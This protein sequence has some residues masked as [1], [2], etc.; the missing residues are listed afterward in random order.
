MQN[1]VFYSN[2]PTVYIGLDVHLHQWNVCI[3]YDGRRCKPFQ[4]PPSAEALAAY[5]HR[6]YPGHEYR[7]A[8][9]AGFCGFGPHYSLLEMGIYNIVFNAADIASTDKEKK[10]KTDAV[11][12]SKIARELAVGGLTPIYTPS[13]QAVKDRSL[14][15][16]R[17]Q[18]VDDLTRL[19]VRIRHFLHYHHIEIPSEY[20]S[21][22]RIAFRKWIRQT[23]TEEI[24]GQ[25]VHCITSMLDH[26]EYLHREILL[27]NRRIMNLMKTPAFDQNFQNLL[28]VPGVG[29]TTASLLLLELG[30]LAD[31][32][33][34]DRF[35]S[36][37]GLVPDSHS[38]DGK[39]VHPKLTHRSHSM[40]RR[41][42][43]E[44]A[45]RA[46][47]SDEVMAACFGR[48]RRRMNQQ[49]AI[50]KVAHKLA[51]CIKFVL[52]NK[53]KYEPE[54]ARLT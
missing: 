21:R 53:K 18:L 51:K 8:Y 17:R 40:L 14:M 28:S 3:S 52:K 15:R 26:F 45:W 31:F 2:P 46:I 22:W 27:I 29:R 11:D 37:L 30:D 4:Q 32:S 23:C 47:C 35:C 24:L 25:G 33:S 10:R 34:V 5:L 36:Y 19:K 7:S 54:K 6:N 38:T 16:Y 42:L 44:C 9:E 12:A 13:Q 20:E 49:K 43:L 41:S 48:W 50:I 39:D 1:H